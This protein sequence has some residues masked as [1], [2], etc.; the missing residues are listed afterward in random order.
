LDGGAD[1]WVG[2]D[3]GTQGARAI[4]ATGT[5]EV[6]GRGDAPLRG[7]RQG[8]RHEQD[9][10]QWWAAV[11]TATRAALRDVPAPAVRRVAVCATSGTLVLVDA[12]L[13]P[14]A[15][16]LMYDDLRAAEENARVLAA[17]PEKV[18]RRLGVRP[19]PSWAVAKLAWLAAALPAELRRGVVL[20][21]ADFVTGRLAG[22]L[23]PGDTSHALKSAADPVTASWPREVLAAVGVPER[24]L[25]DLVRPGTQI[26]E[27]CP[28][29]AEV[30]G[31]PAGTPIV[32]GMTDGCAAQLATGT[33]Q[34]GRWNAVLGTTLV[35]KGVTERRVDDPTGAAYS[36]RAP[37]G[38]WW[39]GGASSTGAGALSHAFPRADLAAMDAAARWAEPA[40]CVIYPLIGRGERFPFVAA[41]AQGFTLGSP[42]SEL[43]RYAALLQGVA[44]LE[45]LCVEHLDA[46]GAPVG[47]PMRVSGGAVRSEAWTQLRADVLG[48]RLEVPAVTDP[49]FGMA[50][51]SAGSVQGIPEAARRMVRTCRVFE[52]RPAVGA[53][54]A[55][56]YHRL[57]AALRERGWLAEAAVSAR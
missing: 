57:V 5:G 16:A 25:P 40:G 41:D 44:F 20:H 42:R 12:G 37:D 6:V 3:L 9:A 17:V 18:W 47:E 11:S 36:H 55:D 33:L 21:Q 34:T 8:P 29:A 45:R 52:P 19:Q 43:D 54:L 26:G 24:A 15:P 28:R 7:W 51:L 39:L 35:L 48:R 1:V 53:R 13:R 38:R 27:V 2:V 30:T 10:E 50:M 46:L 56:G 31:L 32:A 14:M 23:L 49:A 22:R 4:A